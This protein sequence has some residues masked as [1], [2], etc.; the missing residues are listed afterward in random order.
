MPPDQHQLWFGLNINP[1]P[2]DIALL[3][4]LARYADKADM[5]IVGIQ[6]HPYN[7]KFLETCTLLSVLGGITERVRLFP[8]VANLPLRP[9]AMLAKAAATLDLLTGGRVELGLGAGAIWDAIAGYGGPH[10]APGEAVDALE[11]AIEVIHLIW[12]PSGSERV[13]FE[14]QDYYLHEARPGPAPAHQIGIWLGA[15]KP[16]MLRLTGRLA[17]GWSVSHNWVPPEQ[18]GPSLQIIDAAAE[19]AGRDPQVIRRNYN[20]MG[21][22]VPP[23]QSGVRARG[24]GMIVGTADEWV[25]TLVRFAA[26]LRMDTFIFWP[27]AGDER[28]QARRWAE[29]VVPRVRERLTR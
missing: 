19:E 29:E 4:D 6:D 27:V 22:I 8:N 11:E 13:T 26:D 10:L 21:M 25:D 20:V 16:R 2:N 28:D 5:E 23:G 14:G 7:G 1:D 24:Q 18:I 12:R 3:V 15:L 9:P 17:D